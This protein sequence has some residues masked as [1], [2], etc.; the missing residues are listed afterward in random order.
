MRERTKCLARNGTSGESERSE[1]GN[2]RPAPRRLGGAARWPGIFF[3]ETKDGRDTGD[4]HDGPSLAIQ[5]SD[6]PTQAAIVEKANT[7]R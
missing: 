4:A 5:P 6:G 1:D 3:H 7:C 2:R